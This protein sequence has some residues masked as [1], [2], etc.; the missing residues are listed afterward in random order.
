MAGAVRPVVKE[1]EDD[2]K[3]EGDDD[4]AHR[5]DVCGDSRTRPEQ[6]RDECDR[7]VNRRGDNSQAHPSLPVRPTGAAAYSFFRRR[8]HRQKAHDDCVAARARRPLRKPAQQGCF[9]VDDE[10]LETGQGD[11]THKPVDQN[12]RP[13]P[14]QALHVHFQHRGFLRAIP[15]NKGLGKFPDPLQRR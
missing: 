7:R 8:H 2:L 14:S 3:G 6:R 10:E 11:D 15:F 13:Q 5:A 4:E 1:I 9:L 12:E